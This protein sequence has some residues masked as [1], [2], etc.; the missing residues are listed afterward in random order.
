MSVGDSPFDASAD[1]SSDDG[2]CS[3]DCELPVDPDLAPGDPGEPGEHHDIARPG[4]RTV[5]GFEPLV[6]AAVALG[7]AV[8]APARYG[9]AQLVHV[10]PDGFP[11]ATFWTNVSGSFALGLLLVLLLDRFPPAR[12][13]RPFVT[14][15]FLGAYT[16][17]S[18][19]AVESVLLMKDGHVGMAVGYAL[20]SLVIG[21]VFVW[22][23]IWAARAIPWPARGRTR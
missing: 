19:F 12:Y 22:A 10:P 7:G 15:G 23:G 21:F 8:G 1:R 3:V 16:T 11:W 17:Y 20:S 5:R 4:V 6:L 14:T 9:V 18:T 13:L 2:D